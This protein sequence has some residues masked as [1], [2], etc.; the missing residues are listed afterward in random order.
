[1]CRPIRSCECED[2]SLDGLKVESLTGYPNAQV[3][4]V[5]K[6]KSARALTLAIE[7]IIYEPGNEKAATSFQPLRDIDDPVAAT[8]PGSD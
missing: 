8:R 1:M 4:I 3:I 7:G 6:D 2:R 5:D